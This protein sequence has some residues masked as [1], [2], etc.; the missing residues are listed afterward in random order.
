MG[1]NVIFVPQH[2]VRIVFLE[3]WWGH[4]Y[5]KLPNKLSLDVKILSSSCLDYYARS[6]KLEYSFQ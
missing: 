2:T 4:P 1:Y 6:Q 5:W 3:H